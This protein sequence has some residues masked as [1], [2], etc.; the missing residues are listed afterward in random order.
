MSATLLSAANGRA[1]CSLPAWLD[2]A[3]AEGRQVD[4][5]TPSANPDEPST[6]LS[7]SEVLRLWRAGVALRVRS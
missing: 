3:L 7:E 6:D 4:R 1:S 5:A 2:D